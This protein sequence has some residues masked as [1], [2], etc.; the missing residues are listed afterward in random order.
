MR[1]YGRR[2]SAQPVKTL[3]RPETCIAHAP[4]RKLLGLDDELHICEGI[5]DMVEKYDA[6][7]VGQRG[8]LHSGG[9]AFPGVS[10]CLANIKAAGKTIVVLSNFAG[11]ASAQLAKFPSMGVNPDDIDGIITSGDLVY[12]YLSRNQEKLGTRALWIASTQ[13]QE[14]GLSD[15]FDGLQGYSLA[16]SVEDADFFL[17][18]GAES[19]FAGTEAEKKTIFREDG[20]IKHFREI[21]RVGIQRSMLMLCADPE[22]RV[23]ESDGQRLYSGG[24]LAKIYAQLGGR[25]MYFGKPYTA[26]FEE[27]R[28]LLCELTGADADELDNDDFRICHIGDSLHDDVAGAIAVG[29]DAAFIAKTGSHAKDMGGSITQASVG[30]L[31][32]RCKV[33]LPQCVV[34]RFEW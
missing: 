22:L 3:L 1:R 4:R 17:V 33:P 13:R 10:S 7:T 31:C 32:L 19:M 28:Q 6:F 24:S 14:D 8:V 9:T 15:F 26:A 12:G 27:A 30:Q 34:P 23:I 20:M 21:F 11:R 16:S 5:M 25:V 29:M 2:G 18:S